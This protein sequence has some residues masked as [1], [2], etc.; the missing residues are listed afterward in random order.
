MAPIIIEDTSLTVPDSMIITR[1]V[2]NSDSFLVIEA[3]HTYPNYPY[4]IHTFIF[5]KYRLGGNEL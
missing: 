2:S 3:L 4:F 1:A 5:C